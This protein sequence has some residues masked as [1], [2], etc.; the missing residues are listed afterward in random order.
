MARHGIVKCTA[1]PV[2]THKNRRWMSL[3][4]WREVCITKSMNSLRCMTQHGIV[5][6]IACT[7]RMHKNRRWM[8]FHKTME[9]RVNHQQHEFSS[10]SLHLFPFPPSINWC[11]NQTFCSKT[12]C[13]QI[14]NQVG[15][16]FQGN[17]QQILDHTSY[18]TV[19]RYPSIENQCF[20]LN[21]V[22]GE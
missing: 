2:R 19:N 9:G 3:R 8:F 16:G 6:C 18:P 12:A 13:V 20:C 14:L 15:A 22:C 21:R 17:Y 7:V 5:K 10:V 4:S 1:C 11:S